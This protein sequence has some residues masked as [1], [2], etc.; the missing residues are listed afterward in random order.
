MKRYLVVFL[1][2]VFTV[3]CG[4]DSDDDDESTPDDGAEDAGGAF[5]TVT[6]NPN[7]EGACQ[8]ASDCPIVESGEAREA[9]SNCGISCLSEDAE[10]QKTCAEECVV[11]ET[12]LST[13]CAEC[14]VAIVDCSSEYCLA[15]CL[16]DPESTACF[17]CQVD[18]DCRST[19]DVCSGL[20]PVTMP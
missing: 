5:G 20:P 8:S 6:C 14:Y 19:F 10:E 15:P 9:A 17:D 18:N 16:A 13:G 3:A 12:S 4:D 7:G 11:E 2:S 1:L